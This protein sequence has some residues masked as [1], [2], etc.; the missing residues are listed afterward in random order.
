MAA[1]THEY[2]DFPNSLYSL[3][4]FRDLREAPASVAATISQIK[5]L[6]LNGN[7]NAAA[8]LLEENRN[9]VGQY[10]IDATFI[11]HIEEEVR[12]IEIFARSKVQSLYYQ[13]EEPE[14]VDGDVWIA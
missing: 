13:T 3:H 5:S 9:A 8:V 7:Y 11:N 12:N 6:L 2:S 10:M 4:N 1:I 14:G